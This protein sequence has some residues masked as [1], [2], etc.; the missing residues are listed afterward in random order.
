MI[1]PKVVLLI[2]VSGK[3]VITGAKVREQIYTAFNQIYTVLA[4]EFLK[5]LVVVAFVASFI[6]MTLNMITCR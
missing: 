3:I 6:R 5:P 4:G 2:F 1:S